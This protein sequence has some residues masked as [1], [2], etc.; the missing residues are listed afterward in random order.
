MHCWLESF[1]VI[2]NDRAVQPLSRVPSG[3]RVR[4]PTL[5]QVILVLVNDKRPPD[6]R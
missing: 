2:S 5:A 6:H 3:Q 4:K 1:F